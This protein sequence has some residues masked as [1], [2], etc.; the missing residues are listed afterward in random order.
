MVTFRADAALHEAIDNYAATHNNTRAEAVGK[1]VRLG[2][3]LADDITRPRNR[4]MGLSLEDSASD[5]T[6]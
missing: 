4:L 1:L 6:D 3:Q 5:K 2:L